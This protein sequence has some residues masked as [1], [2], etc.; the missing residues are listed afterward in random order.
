MTDKDEEGADIPFLTT[1]EILRQLMRFGF[2]ITYDVKTHLPE[3][4]LDYLTKL[5]GL[6]YDKITKVA[7]ESF[8]VNG[9]KV[10]RSTVIV[11][12]SGFN[13]DLLTFNCKVTRIA[14][15]AKLEANTVMN[16]THELGMSWDWVTYIANISDILDENADQGDDN[17][18]DEISDEEIPDEEIVDNDTPGDD[19]SGEISEYGSEVTDDGTDEPE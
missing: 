9:N 7:L 2:Y 18:S 17:L 16:I 5:N 4:V 14:F 15:N 19:N 6:G 12:K 1:D 8:D 11:F 13:T 10:W 3:P